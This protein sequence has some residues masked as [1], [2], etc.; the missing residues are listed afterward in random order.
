M[1]HIS[2]RGNLTGPNPE[3]ENHPDY[4]QEALSMEYIVEIDLWGSQEGR[5]F[6]GHDRPTYD[7]PDGFLKKNQRSLICHCKN[8]DAINNLLETVPYPHWFW[9][10]T[11]EEYVQTSQ[12][13][14]WVYPGATPPNA[15]VIIVCPERF[16]Q[17]VEEIC[18]YVELYDVAGVCSDY[19]KSI[20]YK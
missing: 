4:I 13:F 3:R 7:I 8:L 17:S 10:R 2:H 1:L 20:R 5:L 14:V 11:D 12:Q 16:I 15:D 18:Q 6:L 19:I 9:H